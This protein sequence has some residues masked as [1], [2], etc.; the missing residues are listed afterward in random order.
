M[1][2]SVGGEEK[3][4]APSVFGT[5]CILPKGHPSSIA[6]NDREVSFLSALRMRCPSGTCQLV[7]G[8]EGKCGS[9]DA[10]T[11]NGYDVHGR[12]TEKHYLGEQC[13]RMQVVTEEPCLCAEGHTGRC[14]WEG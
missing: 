10:P 4:G 9:F 1:N 3:C 5:T 6:H 7:L 12:R 13:R 14:S 11:T 8:H 2:P